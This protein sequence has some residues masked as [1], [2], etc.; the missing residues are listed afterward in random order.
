MKRL[1]ALLRAGLRSNFGLSVI[2]HRM[3]VEKKDRWFIPLFG[4]AALGILPTLYGYVLLLRSL[5]GFL[6]PL[7]QER[8]LLAFGL[9]SGQ[10]LVLLFGFYYVI[11]AF[12][13]SRDLE[14]LVPLPF[15]PVEV[16]VSKFGVILVN[17]YLTVAPI[18]IPVLAVHGILSKARPSYWAGAAAIY[19]LLPIIP[20]AIAALLTVGMM[21]LVNLSRKKDVMIVIGSVIL[22]AA[23]MALQ[24]ALG[25]SAGER[26][27]PEGFAE[28][29]ASPNSL[30]A[31]VGGAF[32]PCVWATRALAE[33]G[34]APGLSQL[35]LFVGLS[36]LLFAG[37]LVASERL[38]YRGL[39]GLGEVSGRR[40]SLS[41][42]EM[43]RRVSS[44][45]RPVRAIFAR[46]WRIMNRTPIF[47]LNGVLTAVMLPL[48]FVV[49][50]K[51]D[52]GS[53]GDTAVFLRFLTSSSSA[54]LVLGAA[55]FMVVCGCLNGTASSAFSREGGQ[56]WLS[57]VIP[58]SPREQVL[59]K[60]A[61]SY[62]VAL[63]G[64]A[65]GAAVLFLTLGLSAS[66]CLVAALLALTAGVGLTAA[67]MIIDLA[68]PLLDWIS[69]TKAIKQNLNVL[70]GF[71]ADMGVLAVVYG[72]V[73][74]LMKA[75]LREASLIA[76]VLA[77]LALISAALLWSLL[78][79]AGRRY[80][81]IEV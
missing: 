23:A 42:A 41:R 60:F 62:I 70:F 55:A 57:K 34:T 44:G 30:L 78:R 71:F 20:L 47:L 1:R 50:S 2:L 33:V 5:F 35:G 18:V 69:P 3:L 4:I 15:R 25:R 45:R 61:H 52:P 11:S 31:R 76:S 48:I 73:R 53:G 16:M 43:S 17:E 32:P 21:R 56:F 24:F 49:M 36:L 6:H 63:L 29:F 77:A 10:L 9:L 14:L 79:F 28:F 22:I 65:A 38:F 54:Y 13:F 39:I 80:R 72:I 26:M 40:R 67:G 81:E 8:A 46:E 51:M 59:A 74:L 58:V 66:A 7:G 75:G 68:R 19:L 64:F 37:I 12:Y 27:G